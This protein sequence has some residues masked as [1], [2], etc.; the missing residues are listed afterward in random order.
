MVS[1][2]TGCPLHIPLSTNASKSP[3]PQECQG[4]VIE[5]HYDNKFMSVGIQYKETQKAFE[6]VPV[7]S[8]KDW[9]FKQH[10]SV[11]HGDPLPDCITKNCQWGQS[12]CMGQRCTLSSLIE[13]QGSGSGVTIHS[14]CLS[15][16]DTGPG[17]L[18]RVSLLSNIATPRPL[19][20]RLNLCV[21]CSSLNTQK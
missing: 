18:L 19:K 9:K 3:L 7:R 16:R 12:V 1:Y 5:M 14:Q 2:V 11:L 10:G 20:D 13:A 21:I 17:V 8:L 4:Q 15:P 6:F